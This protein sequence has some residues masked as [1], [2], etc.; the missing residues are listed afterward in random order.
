MSKK[1]EIYTGETKKGK[2]N[3]FGRCDY[4]DG[5]W[6]AGE[7]K[8]GKKHG[9]GCEINKSGI[10][11]MGRYTDGEYDSFG[12]LFPVP[13]NKDQVL[14]SGQ[15]SKEAF[16]GIGLVLNEHGGPSYAG[17]LI[18]SGMSGIGCWYHP[19]GTV[20]AGENKR[21]KKH[22]CFPRNICRWFAQP[23]SLSQRHIAWRCN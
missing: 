19:N 22:C 4:A 18:E 2:R 9:Q 5:S 14:T 17:Q 23:A 13:G 16:N 21:H 7:W 20:I 15:F 1:D 11:Y 10:S 12:T 8:N 3:G 6:Y